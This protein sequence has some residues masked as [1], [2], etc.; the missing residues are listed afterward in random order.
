MKYPEELLS[1]DEVI[2]RQFRPHW[3]RILR[4]VLLGLVIGALIVVAV[5]YVPQPWTWWGG[6]S[7]LVVGVLLVVGGL[8]R[9][10]TTQHVI[11]NER[12]I[13]RLGI[14]SKEGKEIPLEV[15]NDIAFTQTV[16][17]RVTGSGNLLIESAGEF[18]QTHYTDIPHPEKIQKIIYELRE[19]R[20]EKFAGRGPTSAAEQLSLLSRLH[21]EGKL[22]DAEFDAQKRRL[23]GD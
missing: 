21:D 20:T 16:F 3:T 23:L 11:T 6:L 10:Y 8:L 15:I 19:D 12:I 4:E 22:S 9:W 17:E 1:D 14:V 18:G 2:V 13:H 7:L 5:L